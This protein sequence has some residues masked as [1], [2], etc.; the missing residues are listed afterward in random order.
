[1]VRKIIQPKHLLI[2]KV[3]ASLAAEWFEAAA[4]TPQMNMERHK[5][6][7][8][9]RIF[10]KQNLE[11]FLPTAIDIL[12]GM[13]GRPDIAMELKEEIYDCL[14]ERKNDPTNITSADFTGLPDIDA[15]KLVELGTTQTEK[16]INQ[17]MKPEREKPLEITAPKT[18]TRPFRAIRH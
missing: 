2:E 18:D 15:K 1:M 10:A 14:L 5:Y 3:A 6:K 17:F 8:D 4:N 12:I 13:L 11:K 16:V 9:P 7:N